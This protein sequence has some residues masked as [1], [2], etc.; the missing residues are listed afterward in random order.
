M[1][2]GPL[3][4]NP[5][6]IIRNFI[7][8]HSDWLLNLSTDKNLHRLTCMFSNAVGLL[9][10]VEMC[11]TSINCTAHYDIITSKNMW[12][13]VLSL[14]VFC[15]CYGPIINLRLHGT[16]THPWGNARFR[17]S[18]FKLKVN[19]RAVTSQ[20]DKQPNVEVGSVWVCT[21][22]LTWTN[23]Q[24][25]SPGMKLLFSSWAFVY[26]SL[27]I[28]SFSSLVRCVAFRSFSLCLL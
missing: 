5:R 1:K 13:F 21:G 11:L 3:V 15:V 24:F 18:C 19:G 28:S 25:E 26:F 23:F 12:N 14:H 17:E 22:Q 10:C 27:V 20:T 6:H 9:C 8:L 16:D 7:V 2:Y 4:C